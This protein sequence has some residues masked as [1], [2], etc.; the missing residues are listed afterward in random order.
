M[1][2]QVGGSGLV[3]ARQATHQLLVG[4]KRVARLLGAYA[5]ERDPQFVPQ[6]AK[7][8]QELRLFSHRA[9]LQAV[10]LI[11]DENLG[12]DFAQEAQHQAFQPAE[13]P[14]GGSTRSIAAK[15][16]L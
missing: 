5:Y 14:P 10:D 9:R 6:E 1:I 13:C 15:I 16:R 8:I 12:L 2:E 4:S 11:D 3:E 7:H